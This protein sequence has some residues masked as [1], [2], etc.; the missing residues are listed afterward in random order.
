MFSL[1]HKQHQIE[2]LTSRRP[3]QQLLC[4]CSGWHQFFNEWLQ[5]NAHSTLLLA[6]A[7]DSRAVT[8]CYSVKGIYVH[9][10]SA[11]NLSIEGNTTD[12]CFTSRF[13]SI[14]DQFF[15]FCS[16]V[17]SFTGGLRKQKLKKGLDLQHI[18]D[19]TKTFPVEN[20]L[21]FCVC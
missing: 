8:H 16:A 4:Q 14:F 3:L 7:P 18:S 15:S 9:R 21:S 11:E 12:L 10:N 17:E 6:S 20:N 5:L 1:K 2:G 19:K 13:S